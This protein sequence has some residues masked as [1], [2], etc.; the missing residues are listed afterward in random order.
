VEE[1]GSLP[2]AE[3]AEFIQ[4]QQDSYEEAFGQLDR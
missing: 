1:V 3:R 4:A 2:D